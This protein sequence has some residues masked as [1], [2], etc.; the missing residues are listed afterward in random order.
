MYDV[1]LGIA[2]GLLVMAIVGLG[3]RLEQCHRGIVIMAENLQEA[4]KRDIEEASLNTSDSFVDSIREDLLDTVNGVIQNMQPPTIIDH[5]GGV[6]QQFAQM[7][8]MKAMKEE[9]MMGETIPQLNTESIE[10]P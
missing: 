2:L 10:S 7:K 5:L 8:L 1:W 3:L 9:G 4:F 6:I